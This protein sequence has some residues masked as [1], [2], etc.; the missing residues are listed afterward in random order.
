MEYVKRDPLIGQFIILRGEDGRSKKAG[1]IKSKTEA[2]LYVV[3]MTYDA[4]G[5][6]HGELVA[7]G[8]LPGWE[9]YLTESAWRKAF[10]QN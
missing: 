8:D 10:T 3:V 1:Q 4:S 5:P 9:L 7:Q 2:G 6:P